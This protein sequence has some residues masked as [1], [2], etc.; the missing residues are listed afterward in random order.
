[1]YAT[2][3]V[4]EINQAEL[5]TTLLTHGRCDEIASK[6]ELVIRNLEDPSKTL[7]SAFRVRC[8]CGRIK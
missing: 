6:C 4:G 3:A 1:M 5:A 8:R 2:P 7:A